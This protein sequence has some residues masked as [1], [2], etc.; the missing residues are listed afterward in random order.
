MA[1]HPQMD[2][3]FKHVNQSVEQYL[4]IYG[5][6]E[7][8]DWVNLLPLAQ[9]IHNSWMNKSTGVTPFKLLIGHTPLIQVQEKDLSIPKLTQQKEWLKQGHL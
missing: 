3:Q 9:F 6:E 7:Q 4:Q 2:G 8:N 5:N 1:Y